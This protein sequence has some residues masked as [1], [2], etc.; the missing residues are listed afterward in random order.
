MMFQATPAQHEGIMRRAGKLG[1]Q[2]KADRV[3]EIQ[4]SFEASAIIKRLEEYRELYHHRYA[5]GRSSTPE[6][7]RDNDGRLANLKKDIKEK[8]S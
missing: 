4:D 1:I 2:F 7:D 6:Q 8:I 5:V 3:Y